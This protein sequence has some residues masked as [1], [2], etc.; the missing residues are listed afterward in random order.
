MG[1]LLAREVTKL[2]RSAYR[3]AELGIQS[4]CVLM[5]RLSLG[6]QHHECLSLCLLG[7]DHSFCSNA[8]F[9]HLGVQKFRRCGGGALVYDDVAVNE[10]TCSGK[11]F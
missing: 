8:Q 7:G 5:Q 9:S 4:F 6:E 10:T 1:A 3:A 2:D 11:S